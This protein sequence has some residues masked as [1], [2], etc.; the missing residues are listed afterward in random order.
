MAANTSCGKP[1]W[2]RSICASR[3]LAIQERR[4]PDPFGW[5]RELTLRAD[6]ELY[7]GAHELRDSTARTGGPDKLRY[8]AVEVADPGPVSSSSGTLPSA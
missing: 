3:L 7:R 2:S 1:M 8:E 6:Y 4:A 5:T